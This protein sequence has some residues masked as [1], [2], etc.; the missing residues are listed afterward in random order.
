MYKNLYHILFS[1]KFQIQTSFKNNDT[2]ISKNFDEISQIRANTCVAH[3]KS[4]RAAF[5]DNLWEGRTTTLRGGFHL[6]NP[7]GLQLGLSGPPGASPPLIFGV[8]EMYLFCAS[9]V[10]GARAF[11][12]NGRGLD[13]GDVWLF[14]FLRCCVCE[15]DVWWC[16]RIAGLR[17][18]WVKCRIL[19]ES[20]VFRMRNLSKGGRVVWEKSKGS[21]MVGFVK[22][23]EKWI[24]RKIFN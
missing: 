19:V 6:H 18:M 3:W 11:D 7:E 10:N 20:S 17:R 21:A 8:M 15:C 12:I 16:L 1:R 13:F 9:F 14:T 4:R 23:S 22:C 2:L 24:M 5:R